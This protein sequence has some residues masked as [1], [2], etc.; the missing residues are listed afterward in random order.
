VDVN[1]R[2][3]SIN[4]AAR[5][6]NVNGTTVLV[7]SSTVIR[8]GNRTFA[9]SDLSVGDHVQVK[10]ARS[11]SMVTASEI[12]VEQGGNG[13]DGDDDDNEDVDRTQLRGTVSLLIGLCPGLTMTVSGTQVVTNAATQFVDI[14]CNTLR[15]DM[16]VVVDGIRRN[17][18]SVL[19]KQFDRE[20]DVQTEV[21]GTVSLL[22]GLCPGL[23]FT[24]AGSTVVTNGATRFAPIACSA[25]RNNMRVTVQGIRRSDGSVLATS[26]SAEDDGQ[27]KVSGTVSLLIGLCPGLT[28][29]VAGTQV[30]TNAATQFVDVTCAALTNTMLV[31]VSGIRRNDGS[32]LA[33]KVDR[34]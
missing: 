32:V 23:T 2:I 15:N 13:D 25:L 12:K 30:V 22:V 5:T 27:T 31:E 17:D 24:V 9:F 8:H 34:N 10:G 20:D 29:T 4:N 33:S 11:G 14:T 3:D 28:F 16:R 19:A 1:G 18:V 7:T 6:F 21:R 26:V